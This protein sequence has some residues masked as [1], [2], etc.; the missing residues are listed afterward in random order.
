MQ[1]YVMSSLPPKQQSLAG[2]IFN[3]VSKICGAVGLGISA[4][5]YNAESTSAAALQTSTRPYIMVFWFCAASAGV[6]MLFVPFLTI[7]TQGHSVKD[8]PAES[9]GD[10]TPSNAVSDVE[11]PIPGDGKKLE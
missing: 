6:G 3:T 11:I 7:G 9:S 10:V 5:V 8:T 2:G 4:S 1:M